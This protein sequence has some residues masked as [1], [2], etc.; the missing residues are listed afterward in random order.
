ML[1]HLCLAVAQHGKPHKLRTD[2]EAVLIGVPLN[3]EQR[4]TLK[5]GMPFQTH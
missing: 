5:H 3:P 4:C 2:N 1:G